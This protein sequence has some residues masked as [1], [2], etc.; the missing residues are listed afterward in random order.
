MITFSSI[1]KRSKPDYLV[2]GKKTAE[3]DT[4]AVKRT[5]NGTVDFLKNTESQKL[6]VLLTVVQRVG[7][8]VF[9]ERVV[10]PCLSVVVRDGG[11]RLTR[12]LVSN[13]VLIVSEA[14]QKKIL[15][16]GGREYSLL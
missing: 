11:T 7:T 8:E 10:G 4:T 5:R 9:P 12:C 1:N 16:R 14:D 3:T 2:K 6:T 13:S 15:N